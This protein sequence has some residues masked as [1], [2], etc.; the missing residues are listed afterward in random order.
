MTFKI[1]VLRGNQEIPLQI[2]EKTKYGTAKTNI[3]KVRFTPDGAAQY[4]IF[5]TFNSEPV[6]GQFFIV[7]NFTIQ[8][9][10]FKLLII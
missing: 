9:F 5:I 3:Y 2:E 4:K 7:L 6:K 10:I 1:N 8:V